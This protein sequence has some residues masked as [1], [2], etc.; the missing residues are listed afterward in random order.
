[1]NF[2]EHP[3]MGV[4]EAFLTW[5]GLLSSSQVLVHFD[6]TQEIVL[7]RDASAYG[8]GAVLAQQLADGSEKS[9]GFAL[10]TLSNA[11]KKY[12]QVEKEGASL[13]VWGWEISHLSL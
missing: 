9:I 13:C 3:P 11:E 7:S 5:K 10:W 2:F 4:E 8:I 12:S 1:M 6:P